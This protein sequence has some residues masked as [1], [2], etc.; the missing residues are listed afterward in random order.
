MIQEDLFGNKATIQ[1]NPLIDRRVGFIGKF[2]NRAALVKKV[3]ELG[4]SEKSKDGLTRDTQILVMGTEIKQEDLNRLACYE[5]DGWKPLKISETDLHEIFKGHYAGYET[6]P[7]P[8]KLVNIDMSYYYWNP[9]MI[10]E[11]D[12]EDMGVRC[13]SPLVYG[14]GN[15]IYGMEIYVPKRPGTDMSVIYQLIGNLGGY[16]NAEYF[17]DINVVML[18]DSTLQKLAL[19]IKDDIILGIE[20]QYNK[21]NTKM[22]N[23]QFT[24]ESDFISWVKVRMEKYPDEGTIALLDKLAK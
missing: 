9:P 7:E 10:S 15:P 23:I 16:A 6:A 8:T 20:D 14:E 12:V 17:D 5:H 1:K 13:S 21:S 19:G 3:K 22:F 2:K 18:G 11:E 24:S 4:A